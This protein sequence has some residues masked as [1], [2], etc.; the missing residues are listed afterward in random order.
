MA[1]IICHSVGLL[2]KA[3]VTGKG[4]ME[5]HQATDHPPMSTSGLN[6]IKVLFPAKLP[7]HFS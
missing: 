1:P 7:I 6:Q 5:A 2:D 4:R 3:C